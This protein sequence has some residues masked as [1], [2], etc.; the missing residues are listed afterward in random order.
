MKNAKG[1][2]RPKRVAS[3]G[4]DLNISA[5]LRFSSEQSLETERSLET[6]LRQCEDYA[7]RIGLRIDLEAYRELGAGE[8]LGRSNK[9][10]RR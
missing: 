1:G 6:Q 10:K 7:R 5:Y 2:P 4:G 8:G 3:T 9:F